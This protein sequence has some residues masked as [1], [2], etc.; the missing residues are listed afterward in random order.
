MAIHLLQAK[1]IA[2]AASG[3]LN[4]GEGLTLR[5][6]D[7]QGRWWFRYTG[8]SGQRRA[9]SLGAAIIR[10]DRKLIESSL[11]HAREIAAEARGLLVRGVDPLDIRNNTK[12][13]A[14]RQSEAKQ[15]EKRQANATLVRVARDYHARVIEPNRTP[16]HAAQWIAS[17]EGPAGDEPHPE[18]AKLA[19]LLNR[20]IASVTGP[21]L[22]D[23]ITDL[24]AAVPETASRVRQRLEAILDDAEFR[25]QC[26]GNPARAIRRKLRECKVRRDRGSFAALPFADV[27]AFVQRLRQQKGTAAQALEFAVLTAA[28]TGEVLGATWAEIDAQAGVWRVAAAR[29][30]GAEE[31]VVYLPA[32]A[33]EIVE[34]M[35]ELGSDYVFPS[36]ADKQK[37]LSNMAML[38]LLRRMDT[39]KRTTVHGLCRASFSTWA[40]ETAAARPDVI[41]ACL[42]HRE[43]D[44]IRSAYNRAQFA[45]ERRGLLRAWANFCSG[46]K[47]ATES[48]QPLALAA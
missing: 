2:A 7:G 41:E 20:P 14:R 10:G 19:A 44:R 40:N 15:A 42:A 6:A 47:P 45:A 33:L 38:T 43:G 3:Q 31:H 48:A 36:P 4:D 22:L 30:K 26:S 8:P 1:D 46:E 24:Q 28:R 18:R 9:M 39:D 13:K 21:E 12:Q 5:I 25:G 32:R 34:S 35:R 37:S 29:M 27:P 11:V 16:K 17:I 23:A